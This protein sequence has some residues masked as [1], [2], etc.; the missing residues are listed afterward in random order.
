VNPS[1]AGMF[2]FEEMIRDIP[3]MYGIA[4]RYIKGPDKLKKEQ[5]AQAA[6][7]QKQQQTQDTANQLELAKSA[8]EV[9]VNEQQVQ[10]NQ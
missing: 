9:R 2:D 4:A 10:A 5:Q 8:S 6:A 1:L 7:A 3:E